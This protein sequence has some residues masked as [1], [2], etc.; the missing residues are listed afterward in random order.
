MVLGKSN[1]KVEDIVFAPEEEELQGGELNNLSP[2]RIL[3]VD[4][5]E[6]VHLITALILK[7]CKVE[8]R[9]FSFLNAFSGAEA[10]TLLSAYVDQPFD[11]ILLDI[12][13]EEDDSGYQVARFLRKNLHIESTKILV[14]TGQPGIQNKEHHLD[15]VRLD[16][17]FL[18]TELSAA[19]LR[20]AVTQALN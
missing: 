19:R 12:V 8:G 20:A 17:F 14:R 4:D 3:I 10:K 11:L 15:G 7:E 18:K 9:S 6:D 5:D 13:M 2:W 16:G 1:S